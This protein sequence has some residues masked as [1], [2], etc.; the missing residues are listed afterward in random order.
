MEKHRLAIPLH[1]KLWLVWPGNCAFLISWGNGTDCKRNAVDLIKQTFK[2]AN[3][4]T[5]FH[6]CPS[7]WTYRTNMTNIERTSSV[8]SSA[9]SKMWRRVT[10]VSTNCQLNL[11]CQRY[12]HRF[13]SNDITFVT[14]RIQAT[15]SNQSIQQPWRVQ[16]SNDHMISILSAHHRKCKG[17]PKENDVVPQLYLLPAKHQ[18]L[19]RHP[20]TKEHRRF[21]QVYYGSNWWNRFK[22][23]T[24]FSCFLRP[25]S[26]AQCRVSFV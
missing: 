5:R 13:T 21:L 3:K 20:F 14:S 2:R 6:E 22:I 24:V 1:V 4:K 17:R 25:R 12:P 11:D 26:L 10:N 7:T 9:R 16:L 18:N 15:D 19:S 23:A 8:S